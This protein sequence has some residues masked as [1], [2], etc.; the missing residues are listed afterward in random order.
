MPTKK[1]IQPMEVSAPELDEQEE[2]RTTSSHD[3]PPSGRSMCVTPLQALINRLLKAFIF[4]FMVT[5][6][7]SI[8]GVWVGGQIAAHGLN[9]LVPVARF[10]S[11]GLL[12]LAGIGFIVLIAHGIKEYTHNSDGLSNTPHTEGKRR[13]PIL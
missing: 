13:L 8:I 10:S 9:S 6:L 12:A 11:Y 3:S 4:L 7:L 5:F 2:V 1:T